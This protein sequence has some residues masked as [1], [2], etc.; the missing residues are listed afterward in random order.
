MSPDREVILN[1]FELQAPFTGLRTPFIVLKV[2]LS[3][4]CE[5]GGTQFQKLMYILQCLPLCKV[6]RQWGARNQP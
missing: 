5:L 4:F 2:P 3:N 6:A 1:L